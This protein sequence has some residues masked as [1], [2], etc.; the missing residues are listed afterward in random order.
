MNP[1]VG[2][3]R[4]YSDSKLQSTRASQIEELLDF[5]ILKFLHSQTSQKGNSPH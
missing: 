3:K 1:K 4:D 5:S 2:G